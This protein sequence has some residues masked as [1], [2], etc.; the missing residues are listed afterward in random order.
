MTPRVQVA[1]AVFPK[2][3]AGPPPTP[4]GGGSDTTPDDSMVMGGVVMGWYGTPRT[5]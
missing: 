2:N 5:V 1:Q 3:A 4:S